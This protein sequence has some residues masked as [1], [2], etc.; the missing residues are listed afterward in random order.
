M[1]IERQGI[2]CNSKSNVL[3]ICL[4]SVQTL[5]FLIDGQKDVL[6]VF[7]KSKL[8]K[9]KLKVSF[10][11][12]VVEAVGSPRVSLLCWQRKGVHECMASS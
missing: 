9:S 1:I 2:D 3:Q 12:M 7:S 6:L 4:L 5:Y 8:P 10:G 11:D